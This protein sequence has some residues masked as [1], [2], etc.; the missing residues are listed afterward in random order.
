MVHLPVAV[1]AGRG[2][3]LSVRPRESLARQLPRLREALERHR[4]FRREQLAEFRAGGTNACGTA[5]DVNEAVALREVAALVAE[6]AERALTD[7]ERA[8]IKMRTGDYGICDACGADIALAVLK[9]IPEATLCMTCRR[10]FEEADSD[11]GSHD[12]SLPGREES[13][14]TPRQHQDHQDTP[15]TRRR[16]PRST[17]AN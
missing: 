3:M 2:Q 11:A 8:L 7:I 9:A 16:Q 15:G 5:V 4:E 10:F 6:G 12:R 13:G 17:A 1:I 14:T